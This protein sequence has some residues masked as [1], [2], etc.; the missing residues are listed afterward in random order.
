MFRDW[1]MTFVTYIIIG[2]AVD[3]RSQPEQKYEMNQLHAGNLK[4]RLYL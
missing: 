1:L 4:I 3:G 2:F